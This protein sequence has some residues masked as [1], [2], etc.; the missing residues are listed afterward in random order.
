MMQYELYYYTEAAKKMMT[1]TI[2]ESIEIK[3]VN[4]YQRL[5]DEK[6]K[7]QAVLIYAN[8]PLFSSL[9]EIEG[10]EVVT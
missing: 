9:V 8:Q 3:T 2:N 4:A 6:K 7:T 1:P 10:I 5:I